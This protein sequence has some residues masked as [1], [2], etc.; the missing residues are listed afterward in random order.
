MLG[1]TGCSTHPEG[2]ASTLPGD[3]LFAACAACHGPKGDGN[4]MF[5]APAIAGLPAWYVEAQLWKFRTG[6]RGA[7]PDD[8]DGL[9]MRPMS[10]QLMNP[11]EVKGVAEYVAA[12]TPVKVA[13]TLTGGDPKAGAASWPVCLA[14][15]GPDGRGQQTM[16]A[17]PL[18]GQADWYLLAQLKKFKAGVRGTNPRD[19]TGATMRPMS[20]TLVD[21]QAMKNVVA[22]ISTFPR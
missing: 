17:P 1:S 20:M 19:T 9:R 10:R 3:E 4:A 2:S 7:H 5:R 6:A 14:C 15:H 16:N 8:V 12:L 18:A 21:E 13:A 22:H 11:A